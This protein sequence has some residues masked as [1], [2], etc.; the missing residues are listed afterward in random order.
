MTNFILY[1]FSFFL[2]FGLF[3]P[4]GTNGLYFDVLT[5]L[6]LVSILFRNGFSFITN[7][8][9]LPTKLLFLI[10]LLLFFSAFLYG[11]SYSEFLPI[12]FKFIS[13]VIIFWFFSIE[14]S[15]SPEFAF[16]CLLIFSISCGLISLGYVLGIFNSQFEILN[17]RLRIFGEN[18]NSISSRMA[19]SFIILFY[20]FLINPLKLNKI[21][22]VFLSLLPT[23]VFFTIDTG[24][25]GS[26]LILVL[27]IFVIVFLSNIKKVLKISLLILSLIFMFFM[28][29]YLQDSD[30]MS[31]FQNEGLTDSRDELWTNALIIFSDNLLIGVGEEGYKLE[32]SILSNRVLDTHNLIIY[33]LVTGGLITTSVFLYFLILIF[34]KAYFQIRLKNSLPMIFF[35]FFFFLM[36]KTGGI[37]TYLIMWYFLAYINSFNYKKNS[38]S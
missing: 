32:L 24:S 22:L 38:I 16:K 33:F 20:N 3:D 10:A 37:I 30:I 31:R 11:V 1:L 17:G 18:P 15:K 19:I 2:G 13:A 27:S 21:N 7:R 14:F 4:F 34:K 26:L 25:R 8:F 5:I 9:D 29:V 28:F 6:S 12:N 23:L 36:N 35:V